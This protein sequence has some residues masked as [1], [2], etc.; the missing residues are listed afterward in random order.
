MSDGYMSITGSIL[1]SKSLGDAN[2]GEVLAA[3]D[4]SAHDAVLPHE[5]KK[6]R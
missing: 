3:G 5:K 1:L 6:T 4:T 2:A